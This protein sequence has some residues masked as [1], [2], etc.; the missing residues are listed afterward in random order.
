MV[1]KIEPRNAV[2][3]RSGSDQHQRD[4]DRDILT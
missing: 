4:A 1:A 2:S 3:K